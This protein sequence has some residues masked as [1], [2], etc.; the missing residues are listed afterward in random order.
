MRMRIA[1]AVFA[2]AFGL[3]A[4][5]ATVTTVKQV[6]TAASSLSQPIKRI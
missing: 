1:L 5:L 2:A 3:A 6:R 4:V